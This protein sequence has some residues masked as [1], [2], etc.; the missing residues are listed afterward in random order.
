M[1]NFIALTLAFALTA[2]ATATPETNY[3]LLPPSK[4]SER[5]LLTDDTVAIRELDLPLYARAAQ[6][7]HIGAGGAVT[8]SDDHRWADNPPRAA[9]R[10]LGAALREALGTPVV[11]EPWSRSVTPSLRIDVSVDR[12]IGSLGGTLDFSGD[13][14][15]IALDTS[16]VVTAQGFSFSVPTGGEGFNALT[17]AHAAALAQLA[18]EIVRAIRVMRAAG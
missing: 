1:R 13:F 14:Q 2:C 4:A 11:V 16:K 8:L 15:I 3:Y 12:F 6:V 5:V 10:T 17:N 7:A 18:D 9:T